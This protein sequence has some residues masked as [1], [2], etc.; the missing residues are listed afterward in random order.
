MK[1]PT[2]RNM[3]YQ[4]WFEKFYYINSSLIQL[5]KSFSTA[6]LFYSEIYKSEYPDKLR[7]LL[8]LSSK[9]K[10]IVFQPQIQQRFMLRLDSQLDRTTHKMSTCL[11]WK[12]I[13][14]NG[15]QFYIGT[16]EHFTLFANRKSSF[17]IINCQ[18]WVYQWVLVLSKA[19]NWNFI[20]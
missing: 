3:K 5:H 18:K 7:G 11:L 16:V 10:P 15:W 20:V 6:N 14:Q 2:K 17:S 12:K 8:I 4:A 19:R 13:Y 1:Y 9:S